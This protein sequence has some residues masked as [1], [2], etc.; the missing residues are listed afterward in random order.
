MKFYELNKRADAFIIPSG[1]RVNGNFSA[2]IAICHLP[3]VVFYCSKQFCRQ[4]FTLFRSIYFRVRVN[5]NRRFVTVRS[6]EFALISIVMEL[7]CGCFS[8]MDAQ[9]E[10]SGYVTVWIC[11]CHCEHNHFPLQLTPYRRWT[12]TF[13]SLIWVSS[14]PF[15]GSTETFDFAFQ[16]RTFHFALKQLANELLSIEINHA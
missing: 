2:F 13:F 8:M 1:Q 15:S 16:T 9:R 12:K 3:L 10:V 4:N 11:N 6:R 7:S 5:D 14:W